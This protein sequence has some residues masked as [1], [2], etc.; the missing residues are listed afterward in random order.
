MSPA[1]GAIQRLD[2]RPASADSRPRPRVGAGI[3]AGA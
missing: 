2:G 3:G 1:P